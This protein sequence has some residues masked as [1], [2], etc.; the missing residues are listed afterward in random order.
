[1]DNICQI[2]NQNKYQFDL[3]T[4]SYYLNQIWRITMNVRFN[5]LPIG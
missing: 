2:L 4:K 5:I 3:K 1:M